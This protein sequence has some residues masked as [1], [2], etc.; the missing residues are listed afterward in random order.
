MAY[1]TLETKTEVGSVTKHLTM[2]EVF[3]CP[4]T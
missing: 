1:T 3:Y 2:Q 4:N